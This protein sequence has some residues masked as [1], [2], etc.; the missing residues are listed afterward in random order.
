MAGGNEIMGSCLCGAVRITTK[1]THDRVAACHC[2]M[3][4]KWGGGPFLAVECRGDVH[5]DGIDDISIFSSSEWAE[6]GFCRTCGSHLFYR[7]K[8]KGHYELPIGLFENQ[9]RWVFD[10]QI[11]VDEKPSYYSFANE[12]TNL[13][14]SQVFAQHA[15]RT[16]PEK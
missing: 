7:L 8:G 2:R 9:D 1:V 14:G 3:C 5:F 12:T 11:F 15:T 13:T 4:R 16:D 10:T 6:R